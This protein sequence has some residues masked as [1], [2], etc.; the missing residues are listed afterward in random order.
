MAHKDVAFSPRR[1]VTVA[2]HLCVEDARGDAL[3]AVMTRAGGGGLGGV[4][5]ARRG[6]NNIPTRGFH[7]ELL[8]H[9]RSDPN[10]LDVCVRFLAPPPAPSWHAARRVRSVLLR[11]SAP[12]PLPWRAARP[13]PPSSRLWDSAVTRTGLVGLCLSTQRAPATTPK[14]WWS[15]WRRR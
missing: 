4:G 7:R 8:P 6:M 9:S 15:D 13:R 5:A 1:Y 10:K 3:A 11:V 12:L 14:N 2:S